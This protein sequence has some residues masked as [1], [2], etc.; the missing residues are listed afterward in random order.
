MRKRGTDYKRLRER[1]RRL[2]ANDDR[3]LSE[4]AD[5]REAKHISLEIASRRIGITEAELEAIDGVLKI[6][7]WVSFVATRTRSAQSSS[8]V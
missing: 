5:M 4:L 8:T 3:L 2:I 1:A 6:P 7:L